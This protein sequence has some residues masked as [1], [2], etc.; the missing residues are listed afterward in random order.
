MAL[1]AMFGLTSAVD[2]AEVPAGAWSCTSCHARS[3]AS[4]TSLP[5]VAG[6]PAAEIGGI[7]REFKSGARPATV[8]GRIARGFSDA[9]T[10]AIAEWF[11]KQAN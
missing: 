10:D 6:R 7:M 1:V 8:M 11:A 9:E 4:G 5:V 3:P 2:A